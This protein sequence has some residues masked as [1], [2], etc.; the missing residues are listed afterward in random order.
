MKNLKEDDIDAIL[1]TALKKEPE[2]DLPHGFAAITARKTSRA[3][4]LGFTTYALALVAV[5]VAASVIV[6]MLKL[7]KTDTSNQL[8]SFLSHFKYLIASVLLV[9][10]AI[11]YLDQKLV[12]PSGIKQ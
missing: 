12:R 6:C 11:E 1:L 7:S 2:L 8:L 9:G 5:I 10:L 4:T 3:K